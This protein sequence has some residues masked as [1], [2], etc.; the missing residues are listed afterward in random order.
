MKGLRTAVQ[1]YQRRVKAAQVGSKG[2]SMKGLRTA[3]QFYQRRVKA[4]QVGA[5]MHCQS[6]EFYTRSHSDSHFKPYYRTA[7]KLNT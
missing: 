7:M 2:R 4:A 5:V 3:V 6:A 1:F